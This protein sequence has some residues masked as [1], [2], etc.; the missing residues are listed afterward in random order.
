MHCPFCSATDTRV[1]DSRLSTDGDQVRRR[2]KCGSCGERFTTFE[3][4]DLNMPR[5]MKSDG[6][7]EAFNV[8]KLRAGMMLALEKRPVSMEDIDRAILQIKKKILSSGLREVESQW[9]GEC[10]MQT[11]RDLD[12]VAYIRF[13]SVYR[14]FDDIEEFVETISRMERSA[15]SDKGV[16]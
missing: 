11:L 4:A 2:R 9:I 15:A 16:A 10:V 14:S 5:V 1:V 13:A 6:V 12:G 8:E 7:G 3:V